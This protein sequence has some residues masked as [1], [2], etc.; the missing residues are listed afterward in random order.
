[1]DDTGLLLDCAPPH[2]VP[3]QLPVGYT[4]AGGHIHRDAALRKLRGSDEALLYD[5]SVT[6]AEMVTMLLQRCVV[7]L[8]PF[9]PV[10]L[11]LLGQLTSADRNYLL[12]E[13]RRIT[14]GDQWRAVYVCPACETVVRRTE[15]LASFVVR[16]LAK[17]EKP[18]DVEVELED[19]YQDRTGATHRKVVARLPR[20]ADETFV[21]RLADTDLLQA[22]DALLVRCIRQFGSLPRSALEGYGV[23]I[24][25]ELPLGDRLR[26]QRAFEQATPGVEFQRGV[27]CPGC[28]LEF[29]AVADVTDFFVGS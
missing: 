23:K 10:D 16:R 14:F 7:R 21:G 20:G 26:L 28:G 5:T 4:D 1:M 9:A 3:V 15:D 24:L 19:G 2:T 29:E 8:G 27:E 22:R 11:G 13:L 25:R 18:E 12:Y 6:G 17:D